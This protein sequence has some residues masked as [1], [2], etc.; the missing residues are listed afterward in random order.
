MVHS[1]CHV[2]WGT[3]DLNRTQEFYTALFQWEFMPFEGDANYIM[4]SPPGGGVGGGF[5]LMETVTPSQYPAIYIY[6]NSV[7]ETLTKALSLGG[8]LINAKTEIPGMGWFAF[9][10]DLDGNP[11]GLFEGGGAEA[12]A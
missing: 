1:I 2:E 7:E 5:V 11:I 6:V 8:T 4:Y 9:F 3:T 12:N 10:G